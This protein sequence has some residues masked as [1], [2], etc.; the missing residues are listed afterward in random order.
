MAGLTG[1]HLLLLITV[2][3]LLFG[4]KRLPELA[5]SVG[6]SARIFTGEMKDMTDAAPTTTTTPPPAGGHA[7]HPTT[8]GPD[9]VCTTWRADPHPDHYDRPAPGVALGH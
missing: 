8:P 9:H 3:V 5:R 1:W 2:V 7:P 6:Q 4:A